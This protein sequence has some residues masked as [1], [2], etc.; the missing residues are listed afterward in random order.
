MALKKSDKIIAIIGVIILIVAAV[1]IF[2]YA[3]LEEEETKPGDEREMKIYEIHYDE[4]MR[5]AM[6]DNQDYSIRARLLGRGT[7][8]GVVEITQQN[9]KSVEVFVEYHDNK[10]GLFWRFGRIRAIGAD[11]IT[12][13]IYDS[14]ETEVGRES[15]RGDGNR[16]IPVKTDGEM[17]SMVAIEAEDKEVANQILQERFINNHET[18]TIRISLNTGLWGKIREL[19]GRDSFILDIN[20]KYYDYYLEEKSDEEFDDELPPT[21]ENQGAQTWAP[22]AYPGKN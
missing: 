13:S 8:E 2:L 21:G 15:I 20:Y 11:T 9:L 19:L 18:Y 5:S 12:I 14:M 6:P 17:I 4:T 1:G 10:A 3:D 16:T 7:Y 22:M